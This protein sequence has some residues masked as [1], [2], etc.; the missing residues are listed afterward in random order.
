MISFEQSFMLIT[1]SYAFATL[2]GIVGIVLRQRWLRIVACMGAYAGFLLQTYDMARGSHGLLP[3]G[4]SWGAY[5]QILAWFMLICSFVGQWKTKHSTPLLFMTPLALMLFLFSMRLSQAQI[6]LPENLSSTFY[7]LHIGSLYLSLALMTLAF[8]AGIMF[9]HTERLIKTKEPLTGFRKDF[10][11]LAIL[12]KINAW[13]VIFGFPLFTIGITS[14]LIWAESAWGQSVSG[15]PKELLSF[16][17]WGI[18]AWLFY[19]RTVQSRGGRKPAF[20]ALWLFGL[21]AFS[22]LV[23]NTFMNTHHS[24]IS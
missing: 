17:I 13:C 6:S 14:G 21:S 1:L 24:F 19:M 22:I 18:F 12:D 15:D 5:L 2:C 23:V 20:L 10:P 11:A 7:A 4:L 16:I 9:I 3:G 8:A